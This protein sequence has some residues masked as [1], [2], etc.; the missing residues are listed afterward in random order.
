M[1]WQVSLQ[2]VQ[3]VTFRV[4]NRDISAKLCQHRLYWWTTKQLVNYYER[5]LVFL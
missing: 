4:L 3:Q 5:I 2:K 1:S